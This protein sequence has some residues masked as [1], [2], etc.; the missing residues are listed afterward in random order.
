MNGQN[1]LI[2]GSPGAGK[3]CSVVNCI[4][5]SPREAAIVLD[6]H[7]SSLADGVMRIID[8]PHMLFDNL[9]DTEHYLGF[10]LL[11]PSKATG[12]QRLREEEAKCTGLVDLMLKRKSGASM[13]GENL[14]VSPLRE[15]WILALNELFISQRPPKRIRFY[16][17]GFDP[18][19]DEFVAL[20]RDCS[21][22][23]I[24]KKFAALA[25]LSPR[26]LRAEVASASRFVNG[27]F[28]NREF[29]L[30]AEGET[31]LGAFLDRCGLLVLERGLDISDDA[32]RVLMGNVIQIAIRHARKRLKPV[33]VIRIYID[34]AT[35]AGLIGGTEVRAMAELRKYGLCFTVIVQNPD[36]A[37]G[38]DTIYQLCKRHEW[39]QC[40]SYDLARKAATDVVCGLTADDRS[41]AERIAA[42]TEE[43]M[44]L[45]PGWRWVRDE[46]GSRKE[47]VP[48]LENPWPDWK[49]LRETM[50]QGKLAWIYSQPE[51][52]RAV[53]TP[54]TASSTG[55]PSPQPKSSG[56]SPA[57]RFQR[58]SKRR[59]G[60]SAGNGSE[61]KPA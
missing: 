38:A 32:M 4:R 7:T 35:N 49:G 60:G 1:V 37:C 25:K 51:Y 44:H 50:Y 42:L 27:I 61:T 31:D 20:V 34:E 26:A 22:A 12:E 47:Y 21:N 46:R 58:G 40:A 3:S 10:D 48:L 23:R 53:E 29:L 16:P 17:C 45:K 9:S 14:A 11:S 19:T 43:I 56:T 52:R 2:V 28:K 30:R 41:R 8:R 15:E 24:Q 5:D 55:S 33:P 39:Y 57:A 36:F 6:P 18:T 54:S 59:T 13:T